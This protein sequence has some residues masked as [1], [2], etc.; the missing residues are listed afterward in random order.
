MTVR[1]L[2]KGIVYAA[3]SALLACAPNRGTTYEKSLAEARRAL[4]AG[5][6]DEAAA[7]FDDAAKSAKIPRDSIY[8]RYETALAHARAGNRAR[9]KME[10]LHL[11]NEK[12]E[13]EYTALAAFKA[14]DLDSNEQERYLAL[15][16]IVV[17]YPKSGVA[18]AALSK[19]LRHH[20][21]DEQS[22]NERALEHL[23][24]LAPRIVASNDPKDPGVEEMIAY[25]R[26]KKLAAL[27]RTRTEDALF[28]ML[29]VAKRWPYPYGA[30]YDDALFRAG[31]LER[32]LG[33]SREA[34]ARLEELLSKRESSW[35]VGTYERP[36]YAP[37]LLLIVEIYDRDLGDRAMA[38]NALHRFYR[39]FETSPLRDDA[40]WREA[41]LWQKDGDMATAC[42][43][44][45]TLTRDFPDSRYVPCALVRCPNVKRPSTS[46][47][48]KECRAYILRD[49][50]R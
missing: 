20:E 10:L 31:E 33:R 36:K 16:A 22:G 28:A 49:T 50:T 46:K 32:K 44:L 34:I 38:R 12:P 7:R 15:E 1:S 14:V 41:V 45:E 37:A 48:P 24:Q 3:L 27:G 18:R 5:R 21:Q 42:D 25:E 39:D 9:A 47:A 11:A 23:E 2:A 35:M 30:Y 13:T 40:L 43:R 19:I 8:A 29:D 26:A 17:M 4:H 6:F